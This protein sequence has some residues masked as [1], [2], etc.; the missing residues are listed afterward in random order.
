MK[1]KKK[2]L[3]KST[4]IRYVYTTIMIHED[5]NLE[6]VFLW[7]FFELYVLKIDMNLTKKKKSDIDHS[8]LNLYL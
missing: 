2:N 3:S 8:S 1:K 5:C 4:K 6:L 7:I